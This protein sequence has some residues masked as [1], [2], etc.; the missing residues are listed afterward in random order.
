MDSSAKIDMIN[1]YRQLQGQALKMPKAI[2]EGITTSVNTEF[3]V[4]V[5]TRIEELL[6]NT[7]ETKAVTMPASQLNQEDVD[8]LLALVD[9]VR[10]KQRLN[11][12]AGGGGPVP[13]VAQAVSRRGLPEQRGMRGNPNARPLVEQAVSIPNDPDPD[14]MKRRNGQALLMRE[15]ANMDRGFDPDAG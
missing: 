15:L 4:W 7:P 10:S 11:G 14:G 9:N 5:T 6:G 1:A 3:Q 2:P 12:A 8:V 13:V